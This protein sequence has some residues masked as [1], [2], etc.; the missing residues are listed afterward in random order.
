MKLPVQITFRN[1]SSSQPLEALIHE[2]AAG[3]ET[4]YHPIVGCRVLVEVPHRHHRV[5]NPVHVRVDLTVPGHELVVTHD[6]SLHGAP[7]EAEGAAIAIREAFDIARRQLQDYGRRQ[8]GDVKLHGAP[9][10]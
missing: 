8:R 6:A 5:G 9:P 10:D 4:Y 1:A 2:K 7:G 3:L